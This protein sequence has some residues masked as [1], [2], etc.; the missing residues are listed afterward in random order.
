MNEPPKRPR[1]GGA[2]KGKS[3]SWPNGVPT[4]VVS[5]SAPQAVFDALRLGKAAKARF[6]ELAL[7]LLNEEGAT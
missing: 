1:R 5:I 4:K 2:P 6:Y 3:Y 7:E